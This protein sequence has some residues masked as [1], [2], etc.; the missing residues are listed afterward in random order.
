MQL[1]S[2]PLIRPQSTARSAAGPTNHA[3]TPT[4]PMPPQGPAARPL[5]PPGPELL[6]PRST[7]RARAGERFPGSVWI[8]NSAP[9]NQVLPASLK[10]TDPARPVLVVQLPRERV[11]IPVST[12]TAALCGGPQITLHPTGCSSTRRSWYFKLEAAA[13]KAPWPQ[14]AAAPAVRS[15]APVQACAAPLATQPF[16]VLHAGQGAHEAIYL[17]RREAADAGS[18]DTAGFVIHLADL[19]PHAQVAGPMQAHLTSV[20]VNADLAVQEVVQGNTTLLCQGAVSHAELQAFYDANMEGPFV[21]LPYLASM[22]LVQLLGRRLCMGSGKI[23]GKGRGVA[24]WHAALV[25]L[26][27]QAAKHKEVACA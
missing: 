7:R 22:V 27:R 20:H 8:A 18:D 26:V 14:P 11:Q 23:K 3:A 2:V 19:P 5:L 24:A 10:L 25:K 15:M 17:Q 9:L 21:E 6:P 12:G 13:P 4:A 16:V 1:S